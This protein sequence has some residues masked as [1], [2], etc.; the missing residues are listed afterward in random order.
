MKATLFAIFCIAGIAG[1]ETIDL[2]AQP[3]RWL[4]HPVLG[5]PSFDEWTRHPGNPIVRGAAPF[6]WP[7]NGTLFIDPQS[8]NWYLYVG[9]YP[10]GYAMSAEAPMHCIVLRSKDAGK[11]WEDLGRILPPETPHVYAGETAPVEHA[12]DAYVI[13]ADGKYHMAFDWV[14]A[15]TTWEN[16]TKPG[17]DNNNGVGYA[18][19]DQPEGPWHVTERPVATTRDMK[20][21]HGKYRRLYASSIVRRT[22]DWLILTDVD[23]G[24]YFGWG[25]VGMTAAQPEGPYSEPKLL[26]SP[27]GDT[28]YPPLIEHF[29]SYIGEDGRLYLPG[30]SVAKNRGVQAL[31][32]VDLERA[33]E[34]EAWRLDSLK[35]HMQPTANEYE[36][37]GIWGQAYSLAFPKSGP[38]TM[39]YPSRDANGM[40]TINLA[41]RVP[42][43]TPKTMWVG[44]GDAPTLALAPM[45][46]QFD[47]MKAKL[48]VHGT[49]TVCWRVKAE[50]GPNQPHSDA[51]F[52][53]NSQGYYA[54]VR[55][56]EGGRWVEVDYADKP[57]PNKSTPVEARD[58]AAGTY[59]ATNTIEME[60][61][62]QLSGLSNLV[63]GDS[64]SEKFRDREAW[65]SIG[66]LVEPHSYVEVIS[67]SAAFTESDGDHSR[68]V[69]N[70]EE[71]LLGAAQGD[72]DSRWKQDEGLSTQWG[73][74]C[75]VSNSSDVR[76]KW[77][78]F[79]TGVEFFAVG[80]PGLGIVEV[81]LDGNL[82]K[83][84][85]LSEEWYMRAP[86]QILDWRH[87]D[88]FVTGLP[89]GPHAIV[90]R[91]KQG[92][93]AIT[94]LSVIW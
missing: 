14:S 39:M 82:V 93:I 54:G 84:L 77:N 62:H 25:V 32:S 3:E 72:H 87:P 46:P 81:L 35:A 79:G 40:G 8:E 88:Y 55:F 7:V 76:A 64:N 43:K 94:G 18:W 69:L 24:N 60:Y 2:V 20:T 56:E 4:T 17:A 53:P 22:N 75:Y 12:P 66:I 48:R 80:A 50:I 37:A 61:K 38:P 78:F 68:Y 51:I 73:T 6:D 91:P 92:K 44:A 70:A 52:S 15:N 1:A 34:P 36:H 58:L 13:Y 16:V 29:P 5:G 47:G 65:D 23:S 28:Y 57:E 86:Y 45:P 74:S 63:I 9:R 30:T 10:K 26:L 19:A 89:R 59:N 49:V 83:E 85:D 33:M 90:L 27:E 21:L 31:F 41:T 42:Q 67:M 11:T 71:G